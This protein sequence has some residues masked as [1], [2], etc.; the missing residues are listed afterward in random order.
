MI[1]NVFNLENK[2]YLFNE[3]N[4]LEIIINNIGC[5]I[6][7]FERIFQKLS[8]KSQISSNKKLNDKTITGYECFLDLF[9]NDEKENFIFSQ[10][11]LR[12]LNT[13]KTLFCIKLKDNLPK[14]YFYF[15]GNNCLKLKNESSKDFKKINIK[16]GFSLIFWFKQENTNEFEKISN[17]ISY[18]FS[19]NSLI[20]LIIKNKNIYFNFNQN[21]NILLSEIVDDWNFLIFSFKKLK[22]QKL[23]FHFLLNN[24]NI[25]ENSI[26]G[27]ETDDEIIDIKLFDNFIGYTTSFMFLNSPL[28]DKN[29]LNFKDFI[30][31]FF[32]YGIYSENKLQKFLLQSSNKYKSYFEEL[33]ITEKFS[34]NFQDNTVKN[35]VQNLNGKKPS[36]ESYYKKKYFKNIYKNS[37]KEILL[38]IEIFIVPFAIENKLVLD[39]CNKNDF[40]F[41][42]I[43]KDFYIFSGIKKYSNVQNDISL[44]NSNGISNLIPILEL[45]WMTN[46]VKEN[47]VYF[48]KLIFLIIYDRK[49]N[50]EHIKIT[51]FFEIISL[52][53]EKFDKEIFDINLYNVFVDILRHLYLYNTDNHVFTIFLKNIILNERILLKFDFR[54]QI[55]IWKLLNVYVNENE[56]LH[57][58][59]EIQ[60]LC[61]IVKKI[62]KFYFL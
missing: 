34:F 23:T 57:N 49:K 6:N 39:I 28:S 21:Q 48:M 31:K 19:N 17:L 50:M 52:F 47:F 15:N 14:N 58:I 35:R 43:E 20:N 7:I 54:I 22:D 24:K 10:I 4:L 1:L 8:E 60:K 13:L 36:K 5:D 9:K 29:I 55:E 44:L 56:E 45:M 11:L 59:F 3:L 18:K 2:S 42:N 53:I 61:L 16:N 51:N 62:I 27:I 40:I 41:D 37:V 30:V 46:N 25:I 12:N 26:E 38:H 32:P 33:K